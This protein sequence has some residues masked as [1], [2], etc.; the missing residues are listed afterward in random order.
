[1]SKTATVRRDHSELTVL[2]VGTPTINLEAV[3]ESECSRS[4]DIEVVTDGREAIQRLI[5]ASESSADHTRPDLVLLQCDFE[6]PDGMTV[7]HAIKSSPRL[8]TMPVV[9]IDPDGSGVEPT[10]EAGGN[11]HVRT[12]QTTEAYVDLIDS[13]ERFWF[14]W[15]QYPTESLYS[16]R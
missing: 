1:M 15:A 14:E 9:V 16:D 13:I 4:V 11:A 5:A 7:L 2:F 6:S 12:P 3:C 10:Y 8:N